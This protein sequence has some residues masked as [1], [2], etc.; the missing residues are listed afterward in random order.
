MI[1][2]AKP[3]RLNVGIALF[4]GQGRVFLGQTV[5]D[6]PERVM[7]GLDWQMPQGGV[8]DG[9]D[10]AEAAVRELFE[11]TGIR[12]C[13]ILKITDEW[14]CYEFPPFKASGHRLEQFAGQQQRWVAMRFEGTDDDIDLTATGAGFY[15]EFLAWR[16]ATLE[17]A[18]I[19]VV[20]WKRGVYRKVA[21][22]FC[23]FAAPIHE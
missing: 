22:V 17:E 2:P 12:R 16:W 8:D 14:W 1:A 3:F 10:I 5:T 6:G 4:N 19:G 18:I 11:E 13:R 7:P 20:P 23:V 15:P 9:E 21:Q